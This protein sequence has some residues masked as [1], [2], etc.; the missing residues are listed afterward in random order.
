MSTTLKSPRRVPPR[1]TPD[2]PTQQETPGSKTGPADNPPPTRPRDPGLERRKSQLSDSRR[3]LLARRLGRK[4][5]PEPGTAE[6]SI[7][8]RP[9]PRR[10]PLSFE[11]QRLWRLAQE[12]P[13]SSLHN[14][15]H[16]AS[17]DGPLR[18]DALHRALQE[19]VRRHQGLRSQFV[20]TSEGLEVHIAPPTQLPLPVVDLSHLPED[21]RMDQ[22]ERHLGRLSDLRFD[23]ARSPSF[24]WVLVRRE[25]RRHL[26]VLVLHHILI[27]GWSL[28]ILK[29]ELLALYDAFCRGEPSPLPELPLQYGDFAQWQRLRATDL[30]SQRRYWLRE[31]AG[32]PPEISLRARQSRPKHRK[33][34]GSR[35]SKLLSKELSQA[36]ESLARDL[37]ATLFIVCLAG[38]KVLLHRFSHQRDLVV[39]TPSAARPD[40]VLEGLIGNFLSFLPV[41]TVL[42]GDPTFRQVV[43]QVREKTLEAYNHQDLPYEQL[44]AELGIEPEPQKTPLF[45][46]VVNQPGKAP[47]KRARAILE[48]GLVYEPY[49]TRETGS[50]FDLLVYINHA[51]S[52]LRIQLAY[53]T[54]LFDADRLRQL[55]GHFWELLEVVTVDPDRR[56]SSL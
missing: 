8:R 42:D 45:Q 11:Q 32:A 19:I 15:R 9:D 14:V 49:L 29:R 3:T 1:E 22:A 51:G 35:E 2:N 53:D 56:I 23:L 39:G 46:I 16:A 26:L 43:A 7:P 31:L 5:R 25:T 6:G 47:E 36:L 34:I 10:A 50:E 28:Q 18:F 20:D 13:D 33:Y 21:T 55:C 27:D 17:L 48:G 52:R 37:Q 44:T 4:K 54:E 41:R 38:F 40:P 24:R 12:S 30:E